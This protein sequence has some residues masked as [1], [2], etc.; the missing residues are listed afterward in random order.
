MKRVLCFLGGPKGLSMYL[1]SKVASTRKTTL[2]SPAFGYI[3]VKDSDSQTQLPYNV[4]MQWLH[5]KFYHKNNTDVLSCDTLLA[6]TSTYHATCRTS[7]TRGVLSKLALYLW[8]SKS[9]RLHCG[10]C[11]CLWADCTGSRGNIPCGRC[12]SVHSPPP[13]CSVI[14]SP[15]QAT[16]KVM[17]AKTGRQR[18]PLTQKAAVKQQLE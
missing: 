14:A 11:Q 15:T 2:I 3:N 7:V 5:G 18:E 12:S 6:I 1:Y 16:Y 9:C 8:D 4:C 10:N 17:Y 13:G